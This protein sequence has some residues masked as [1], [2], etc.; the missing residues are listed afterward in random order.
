M[1]AMGFLFSNNFV[2][3]LAFNVSGLFMHEFAMMAAMAYILADVD[4]T[5]PR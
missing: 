4:R 3:A 1:N 2:F 5:V